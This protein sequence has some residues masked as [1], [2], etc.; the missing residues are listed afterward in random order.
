MFTEVGYKGGLQRWVEKGGLQ[1]C[2][3][4]LDCSAG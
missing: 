3:A 2:V 4:E 1:R